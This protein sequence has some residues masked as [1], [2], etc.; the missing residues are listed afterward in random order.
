MVFALKFLHIDQTHIILKY[1]YKIHGLIK[2]FVHIYV[3]D[4]TKYN[5]SDIVYSEINLLDW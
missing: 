3:R 4:L 1:L 5:V 2:E